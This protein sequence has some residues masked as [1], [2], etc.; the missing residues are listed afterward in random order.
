MII[1]SKG[2]I[3][4][5]LIPNI[6]MARVLLDQVVALV[7][8]RP[9][10][11]SE[12]KDK[13]KSGPLVVFS[14]YPKANS[15]DPREKALEDKIN[16][17]LVLSK[18][19]DLGMTV[20]D[21]KITDHI[22]QILSEYSISLD[23]LK[24][25]VGA[26]GKSFEEYKEDIR[27]QMLV[28]RFRGREI[29]SKIKVT[30]KDLLGFYEKKTGFSETQN[31][32]Y[33]LRILRLQPSDKASKEKIAK[34]IYEKL[35]RGADIAALTKSDSTLKDHGMVS[36]KWS[37]LG[38]PTRTALGQIKE[39]EFTQPIED[40]NGYQILFLEGKRMGA[41]E[42]FLE[43][44]KALDKE[45]RQTQLAAATEAWV[46]EARLRAKIVYNAK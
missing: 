41:N 24:E 21:E 26:Q 8:E 29:L 28:A 40:G 13:V 30:D 45:L 6:A 33:D 12:L 38:Q 10:L 42:G 20:E 27:Q 15:Q 7:N 17:E 46:R 34:E 18:A 25:S 44:K 14:A 9:I 16:L 32:F 39:K 5:L 23:Q 36:V 2:F 31:S 43:Q 22:S 4:S 37:D 19:K 11:E 3:L 35:K 1:R